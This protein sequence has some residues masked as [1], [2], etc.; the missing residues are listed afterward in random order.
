MAIVPHGGGASSVSMAMPMLTPDNY[1]VWAIKAQAILDAHNLWEAV[2]PVGDAAVNG[3]KCKTARA[4]ILSGLPEDVLLQVATKLTTR[5]VW[6][7]LKV[8]FDGAVRVRVAQLATLRGDFDRLK[9]A[10]DEALDAYAG[11]LGAITARYASL[12]ETLGDAALVKKL[13]DTVPDRLFPVVAGIKQFCNVNEMAFDEALGRLRAFD[14]RMR[15]HGKDGDECGGD[16]L[17][18]PMEQWR[19]RERQ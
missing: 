3:K 2:A 8:R 18:L 13:L 16:Q 11:R 10:D 7:S 5:E 17:L 9:M 15:R 4:M 14:E 1:T 19:A 12:G 6:D